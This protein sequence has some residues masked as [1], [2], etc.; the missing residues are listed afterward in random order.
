MY[1]NKFW[2]KNFSD[3]FFGHCHFPSS[4]ATKFPSKTSDIS[5]FRNVFWARKI[6][7]FLPANFSFDLLIHCESVSPQSTPP[8][9]P[10]GSGLSLTQLRLIWAVHIYKLYLWYLGNT[11]SSIAWWQECKLCFKNSDY[12]SYTILLTWFLLSRFFEHSWRTWIV[13]LA[14]HSETKLSRELIYS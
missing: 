4:V 6:I 13:L 8:T 1:K 11:D 9:V 7:F 5:I 12:E 10:T 14:F 3:F 2:L